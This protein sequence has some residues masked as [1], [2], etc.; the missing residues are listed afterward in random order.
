[1]VKKR[2]LR[3]DGHSRVW[4]KPDKI[5]TVVL[6]NKCHRDIASKMYTDLE[7]DVPGYPVRI[8]RMLRWM[9]YFYVDVTFD[10]SLLVHDTE[11]IR[12]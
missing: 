1:M 4:I 2:A 5:E 10:C 6:R 8:R 9:G 3:V 7:A 11:V 12:E